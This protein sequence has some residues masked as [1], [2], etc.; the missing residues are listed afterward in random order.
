MGSAYIGDDETLGIQP[1][2]DPGYPVPTGVSVPRPVIHDL[3]ELLNE[4]QAP[5]QDECLTLLDEVLR[6]AS[7]DDFPAAFLVTFMV[8]HRVEHIVWDRYRYARENFME[9]SY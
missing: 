6:G 8:L 9:V 5:L 2:D 7:Q 4:L 1:V 3:G